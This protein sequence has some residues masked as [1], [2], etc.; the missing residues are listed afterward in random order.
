MDAKWQCG[1]DGK[2]TTVWHGQATTV[3]SGGATTT[4][5]ARTTK[6]TINK[7][8]AAEAKEDDG[9]REVMDEQ[10]WHNKQAMAVYNGGGQLRL[11]FDNSGG[12]TTAW[13][14]R[15]NYGAAEEDWLRHGGEAEERQLPHDHHGGWRWK[16]GGWGCVLFYV[17]R[18]SC[19][20]PP[21]P[22]WWILPKTSGNLFQFFMGGVG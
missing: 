9:W 17:G 5:T 7:C 10:Q 18:K 21:I 12:L 11:S 22:P 4:L 16:T 15:I 14:R 19:F 13:Q 8:A 20:L 6:T 2:A 1:N 3:S